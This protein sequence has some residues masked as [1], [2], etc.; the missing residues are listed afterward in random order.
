MEKL[1]IVW[2]VTAIKKLDE[3]LNFYSERN[4]SDTYSKKLYEKLMKD[5]RLLARTPMIGIKTRLT[6]VHG[7]IID[8]FIIYYELKNKIVIILTVWDCAQN[9]ETNIFLE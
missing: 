5:V 9:P 7:L 4:Q 3:I 6:N 1:N 8:D 2:S